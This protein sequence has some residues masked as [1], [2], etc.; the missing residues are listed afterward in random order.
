MIVKIFV[1]PSSQGLI[2]MYQSEVGE[3]IIGV[4][5]GAYMLAKNRIAMDRAVGDFDSVNETEKQLIAKYAEAVQIH[6]VKKDET[7][8]ALALDMALNYRPDK[9]IIYG[10]IGTRFDHTYANM[11]LLKKG[12]IIQVDEFHKMYVLS[13]GTYEIENTYEYIS[14]FAIEDVKNLHLKDFYYPLKK[15]LLTRFDPL[16]ISNQGSGTVSFEDGLLLVVHAND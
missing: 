4:E 3:V 7:D 14:F 16:C 5:K 6:E 2:D 1:S 12:N 10:G 8:T 13:P 11:L 9:I 15:D